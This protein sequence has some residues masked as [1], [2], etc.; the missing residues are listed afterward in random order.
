VSNPDNT[1]NTTPGDLE[2]PASPPR[3]GRAAD[4]GANPYATAPDPGRESPG[5]I[6]GDV[7]R[8]GIEGSG[9]AIGPTGSPR[10]SD[11]TASGEP[12]SPAPGEDAPGQWGVPDL[13]NKPD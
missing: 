4:P 8:S 9:A 3:D 1:N 7:L 11:P 2:R 6:I 10:D 5:Q 13:D 12:R